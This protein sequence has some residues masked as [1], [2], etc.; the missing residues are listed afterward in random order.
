MELCKEY[1]SMNFNEKTERICES[2]DLDYQENLPQYLDDIEKIVKCCVKNV[3]T[4]YECSGSTLKIYGKTI[5]SLTYLNSDLCPLS[6]IFEEEFSKSFDITCGDYFFFS[7]ININTKYSNFRLINQRRIDVHTA[8]SAQID[9]YCRNI[10]KCLTNCKNAFLKEYS[11]NTLCNK[12]AGVCS[13]EFDET[14]S[15]SKGDSVIKNVINTFSN[16]IVEEKK[17]IKDKML[18]KLRIEISILYE[19]DNNNIEKCSHTFTVS[20]I[21]DVANTDEK[22]SAFVLASISSIY[23]KTKSDANNALRDIELVG[24]VSIKYQLYSVNEQEFI[25][26]SYSPY[27]NTKITDSRIMLKTSPV[28]FSDE[29]TA[30]LIFESEKNI[31]QIL[32]LSAQIENCYVEKSVLHMSV[33]LNFLYYDDTSQ[34]Y[35]YDKSQ[36]LTFALNDSGLEGEAAANLSSYDFVIKN[37][38]KVSLRINFSYSAYLYTASQV[39]YLVDIEDDGEKEKM[40]TPELTLYFADKNE[41]IWDIAKSFSTATQLIMEENDL[42]SEVIEDKRILLVPGM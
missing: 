20:K 31:V 14:F 29:K 9:V 23:V 21:V 24:R 25:T 13:A 5:I 41:N 30:E 3:V 35:S 2:F 6:H 11:V 27:I 16:C 28:F 4:D 19:D 18:V 40:N 37:T 1:K 22:D 32:D 38:D 8:V 33:N 7:D 26:D 15:I 39:N 42:S 10:N 36:E 34:L 17:I 12:G